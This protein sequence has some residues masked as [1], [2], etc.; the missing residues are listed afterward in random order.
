MKC[1]KQC[2]LGPGVQD[3]K[4]RLRQQLQL[5]SQGGTASEA[6]IHEKEEHIKSLQ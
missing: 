2:L 3:D 6:R 1:A 4:D 5:A